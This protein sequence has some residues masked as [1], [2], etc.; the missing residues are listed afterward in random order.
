MDIALYKWFLLNPNT[1]VTIGKSVDCSINLFV[2]L[3]GDIAPVHCT[4]KQVNDTDVLCISDNDVVLNGRKAK[5]HKEYK[6]YYGDVFT[7]GN[8]KFRYHGI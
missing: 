6:L 4:I 5:Y 7:I 2:D 8:V 1:I 3:T